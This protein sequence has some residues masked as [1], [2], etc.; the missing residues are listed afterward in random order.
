MEFFD[1]FGLDYIKESEET[2]MGIISYIASN[3]EAISGYLGLPYINHHL[4]DVQV[5]LHTERKGYLAQEADEEIEDDDKD[6]L[7]MT[8]ID[9]HVRGDCVWNLR[10]TGINLT[11]KEAPRTERRYLFTGAEE[12]TGSFPVNIVNADVMPSF[13]EDDIMKIQAAGYAEVIEYFESEEEAGD[14]FPENEVGRKIGIE[15][16]SLFPLGF[17]HNHH[18]DENGETLDDDPYL[19]SIVMLTAEVKQIFWGK[20]QIADFEDEHSFIRCKVDTIAGELE[21]IHSV[22]QVDEEQR[23]LMKVGS[24]IRTQ[25]ILCG[26]VAIYEYENGIIRDEEH[27]LRTLRGVFDGGE[28]PERLR[29]IL[30]N[31]V[32]HRGDLNDVSVIGP[33][34]V[35]DRFKYVQ[36]NANV[37]YIV[38]MA[39]ITE[40]DEGDQKLPFEEGKR[41]LILAADQADNFES[42]CFIECNEDGNITWIH[43]T[44]ESRYRFSI[45]PPPF[46]D[47]PFE[48]IDFDQSFEKAI[49]NRAKYHMFI[50]MEL[51]PEVFL[52]A[53]ESPQWES[54]AVRMLDVWPEDVPKWDNEK[55]ENVF[56]YLFAKAIEYSYHEAHSEIGRD[57]SL[58]SYSPNDA[59]EGLLESQFEE[60]MHNRLEIAMKYG[61]QFTTDFT[62]NVKE[63]SARDYEKELVRALILVQRI[64][65]FCAADYMERKK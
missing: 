46:L 25:C 22:D 10:C 53:E 9:T 26:D 37:E 27:N 42:I 6:T 21:I 63:E 13:L 56:G 20:T 51:D 23:K 18:V 32:A 36:D 62:L 41:C 11:P 64:G 8:N 44:N 29:R 40:V 61:K 65:S 3:G 35:I 39:T 31:D 4:G 43:T 2:E 38:H 57:R 12:H 49:I 1:Q 47:D 16:G 5:V 60:E 24:F 15:P 50:D 48:G 54:N 52:Q 17:M 59:Y 19:D 28:S 30:A 34:A 45:D 14:I 7:N 33:D 58:A 55:L